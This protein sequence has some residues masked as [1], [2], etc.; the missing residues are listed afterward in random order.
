MLQKI[1]VQK[2]DKETIDDNDDMNKIKINKRITRSYK[3]LRT[4]TDV[5]LS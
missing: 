5:H 3:Q 4:A 1:F 2:E